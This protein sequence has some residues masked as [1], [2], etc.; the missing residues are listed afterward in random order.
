MKP[1]EIMRV[2]DA[3][4]AAGRRILEFYLPG[5]QVRGKEYVVLNPYRDDQHAGSLSI[6]IATGKGG[7]FATGDT[8]GDFVGLVA[9]ARKCKPGEA[10]TELARF[11]GMATASAAPARKKAPP[12]RT[13]IM[14]VPDDAPPPPKAHPSRGKPDACY[15]Y[16][17][18]VGRVQFF[19]CRWEATG[20]ERKYF[21]P[22][23]WN[24]KEWRWQGPPVPR[25]L[26]ALDLIHDFAALPIVVCE[27]EKSASALRE[28]LPDVIATAW[29]NG[30]NAA[31]K[32]DWTPLKG[33]QVWVWA[34][35]D[36]HGTQAALTAAKGIRKAG[37]ASVKFVNLAV[38]AKHT[39]SLQGNI[40]A[41]D[42]DLP[43]GWDAADAAA[44]GW[45]AVT[46]AEVLKR[47][48]M[49]LDALPES[50]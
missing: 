29:P 27:G 23:I 28:A 25:P 22:L 40:V 14:P 36:E 39:I 3:A 21:S 20:T 18:A 1:A 2:A 11:I 24:G 15:C 13:A 41:R 6:E 10:A 44:E 34:D 38:F 43:A 19:V 26:F 17:D 31:D 47:D 8:F 33:R 5:G 42:G 9:F 50:G 32:A 35:R 12:E 45:T 46:M 37:A 4:K 7:D 30:A 49:L 48:D 16:R